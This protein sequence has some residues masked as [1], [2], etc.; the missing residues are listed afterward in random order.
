MSRTYRRTAKGQKTDWLPGIFR[1]WPEEIEEY[2]SRCPHRHRDVDDW[3]F[4]LSCE[5]WFWR[6]DFHTV[7]CRAQTRD[8]IHKVKRGEVDPDDTTWPD[9][10]KPHLYYW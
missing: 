5:P 10:R 2:L 3:F 4:W 8:L 1:H 9:G 7:P 6:H